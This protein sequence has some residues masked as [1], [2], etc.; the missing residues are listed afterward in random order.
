MKL[1]ECQHFVNESGRC[2]H[3]NQL[4][5]ET[6]IINEG[7]LQSWVVWT[8]EY[9]LHK[10]GLRVAR[11][12]I[13]TRMKFSSTVIQPEV[14]NRKA[15]GLLLE[16]NHLQSL[17]I[18]SWVNRKSLGNF[19]IMSSTVRGWFTSRSKPLAF[20]IRQMHRN[21]AVTHPSNYRKS[22]YPQSIHGPHRCIYAYLE[23][24]S[25][26]LAVELMRPY[27]FAS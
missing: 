19:V 1:F 9:V 21:K 26:P 10:P 17:K 27:R 6:R 13:V 12:K 25:R 20:E 8:S 11:V 7:I 2:R 5:M 3:G 16:V 4:I 18:L 24:T 14:S 22:K 23:T 15:G